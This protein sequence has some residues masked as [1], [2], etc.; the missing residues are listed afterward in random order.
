MMWHIFIG[1]LLTS[2]ML[3]HVIGWPIIGGHVAQSKG[4]MCHS[5]VG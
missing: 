2:T 4:A 5:L 1:Q 3:T